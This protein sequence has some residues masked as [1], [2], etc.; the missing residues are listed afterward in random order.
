MPL[1]QAWPVVISGCR[2]DFQKT[3]IRGVSI[4]SIVEKVYI[5]CVALLTLTGCWLVIAVMAACG[6]VTRDNG[7]VEPQFHYK[8]HVRVKSGFY[9]GYTGIVRMCMDQRPRQY[10]VTMDD[11]AEMG[12]AD[13][14]DEELLEAI[15]EAE[16]Q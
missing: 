3:L 16:K 1:R 13:F 8:Q 11:A 6:N 5:G 12:G 4:M 10:F 9:A 15:P 2:R 14:I 7:S